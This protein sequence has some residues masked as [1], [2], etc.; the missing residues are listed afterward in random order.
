[1]A[2]TSACWR[3]TSRALLQSSTR[4]RSSSASRLPR[5]SIASPTVGTRSFH[6]TPRVLAAQKG[7]QRKPPVNKPLNLKSKKKT[8]HATVKKPEIGYRR[9]LRKAI[10]LSN[11]NAPVL[12]LP[13][14]T[15]ELISVPESIGKVFSINVEDLEK[16]R[17]LEVFQKKQ[18]WQYFNRPTTFIRS[19]SVGLAMAMESVERFGKEEAKA[20][21]GIDGAEDATVVE[22][23]TFGAQGEKSIVDEAN[24][25]ILEPETAEAQL[26]A[27]EVQ[28]DATIATLESQLQTAKDDIAAVE[29]QI[30]ELLT[31]DVG[32]ASQKAINRL[33][34]RREQLQRVVRK[35]VPV[36]NYHA[37][38]EQRKIHRAENR[39]PQ[40][41][42]SLA[43]FEAIF[44][45][46]VEEA[47]Q[48]VLKKEEPELVQKRTPEK[49]SRQAVNY[50]ITGRGGVGKSILLLQAIVNAIGRKWVVMTIPN[51]HDVVIGTTAY[52]IN[53][54]TGRYVQRD[55]LSRMLGRIGKA[56]AEVLLES[57][58]KD[59]IQI[60]STTI[61]A[62]KPLLS[63]IDA[64]SAGPDL[65]YEAFNAFL[66]EL[67]KPGAPPV[68]FALDNFDYAMQVGSGY[69]TPEFKDVFP[70][71]LEII[72]TFL[73]Y[74]SGRRK[75]ARQ[76][77][78]AATTT[79]LHH[80][81]TL[82]LTLRGKP[83]PGIG[84][85]DHRIP[86]IIGTFAKT[87][88]VRGLNREHTKL[89]LEFYK[90]AGLWDYSWDRS[91]PI[92]PAML[93][94]GISVEEYRELN[95]TFDWD[96][97]SLPPVEER[98][99]GEEELEEP[100]PRLG[101]DTSI[102]DIHRELMLGE[103]DKEKAKGFDMKRM[104]DALK[105]KPLT[106][107]EVVERYVM[108]SGVPRELLKL[109]LRVQGSLTM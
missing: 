34:N 86:P 46:E 98:N 74:L 6:T 90:Q 29:L 81:P 59:D 8:N 55:Y 75:F 47:E 77:I 50:I 52:E 7:G 92:P 10:I 72:H 38:K 28:E 22:Q 58:V 79:E 89:L 16:L 14:L 82:D 26:A 24:E 19:E 3:C 87:I 99:E 69:K 104:L 9:A 42:Q 76:M 101:V 48:R 51:A 95:G 61:E 27:M 96:K 78:I 66:A 49:E 68:L 91:V 43:D 100:A 30:E 45:K 11:S 57:K 31:G 5:P 36:L 53:P 32:N 20:T 97:A 12:D 71:D 106:D 18:M 41:F 80:N 37:N 40:P 33:E 25:L 54:D 64:G 103:V 63:I 85:Y 60:G 93:K 84:K 2:T 21:A 88:T 73:E 1:M 17:Q 108:T 94:A 102:A 109:C 56:N 4:Y 15:A 105:E 107:H 67:E 70:P 65:S 39:K 35:I 13:E 62:G 83:L 23:E 44:K